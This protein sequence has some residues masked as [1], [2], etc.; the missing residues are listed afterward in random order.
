MLFSPKYRRGGGSMGWLGAHLVKG[1]KEKE[2]EE[3]GKHSEEIQ[4]R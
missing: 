3:H 1:K 4:Y 2:K